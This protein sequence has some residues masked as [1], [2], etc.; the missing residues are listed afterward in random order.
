M[1]IWDRLAH[2]ADDGRANLQTCH[3]S[4]HTTIPEKDGALSTDDFVCVVLASADR[5]AVLTGL[6]FL[7]LDRTYAV[8]GNE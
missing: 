5:K 2:P 4:A 1:R 3:H 8:A 6:C 7:I